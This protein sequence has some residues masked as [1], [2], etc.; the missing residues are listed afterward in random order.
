MS[1]KLSAALR[2]GVEDK[3]TTAMNIKKRTTALKT[4]AQQ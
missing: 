2:L 4:E 3:K 1:R